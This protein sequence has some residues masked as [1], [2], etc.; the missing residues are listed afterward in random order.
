MFAALNNFISRLDAEP[1]QNT[2][3]VPHGFQVVRNS[4]PELQLEPWYDFICGI[5]GRQLVRG[6]IATG[7]DGLGLTCRAG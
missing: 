5:N 3:S 7:V 4:D 1:S 6:S 2:E